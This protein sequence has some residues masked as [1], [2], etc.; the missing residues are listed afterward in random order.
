MIALV[1]P[2]LHTKASI[3]IDWK[4][5]LCGASKSA[6]KYAFLNLLW[7]E[8]DVDYRRLMW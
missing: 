6:S 4:L 1:G 3:V 5:F 2:H 8:I 7:K